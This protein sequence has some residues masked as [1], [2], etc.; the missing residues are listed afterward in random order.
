VPT[1]PDLREMDQSRF[2]PE[3]LS[4][5]QSVS[6]AAWMI[7]V[8]PNSPDTSLGE[9]FSRLLQIIRRLA[10]DRPDPPP[11]GVTSDGVTEDG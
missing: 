3:E 5:L 4:F 7:S 6:E 11:P 8:T 9:D 1:D 10:G 2:T